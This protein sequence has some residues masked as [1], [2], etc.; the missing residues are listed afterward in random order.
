LTY[1]FLE[2]K[3]IVEDV[4]CLFLSLI[5]AVV[6]W[7]VLI[8]INGGCVIRNRLRVAWVREIGRVILGG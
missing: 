5:V 4:I 2:K 3:S 6:C 7:V 8:G 1:F